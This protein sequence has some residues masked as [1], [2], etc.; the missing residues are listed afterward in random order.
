MSKTKD[1]TIESQFKVYLKRAKIEH[2][3]EDSVQYIELKRAFL[4]GLR[5]TFNYAAR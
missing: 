1:Y 2:L 4:C 5:T 3:S